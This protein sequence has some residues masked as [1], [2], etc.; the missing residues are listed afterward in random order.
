MARQLGAITGYGYLAK[1]SLALARAMLANRVVK[2]NNRD[3]F[4][5]WG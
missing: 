3:F 5:T 2:I 1:K 4:D